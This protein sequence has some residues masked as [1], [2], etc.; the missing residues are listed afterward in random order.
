MRMHS[1]SSRSSWR[2]EKMMQGHLGQMK[3]QTA[4][5]RQH[6][7]GTQ[8]AVSRNPGSLALVWGVFPITLSASRLEMTGMLSCR[9]V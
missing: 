1:E 5:M 9:G 7:I 2:P 8:A 6:P 3:N 4:L